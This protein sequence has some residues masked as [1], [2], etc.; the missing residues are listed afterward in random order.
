MREGAVLQFVDWRRATL[1][2]AESE[3]D[4]GGSSAAA[5]RSYATFSG[6][7][8]GCV[9]TS[10]EQQRR[11]DVAG[12]GSSRANARPRVVYVSRNDTAVRRVLQE[13]V[14]LRLLREAGE[15]DGWVSE[16]VL[17][18]RYSIGQTARLLADAAVIVGP[19]GAGLYNAVLFARAHGCG[20]GRPAMLVP[21]RLDRASREREANLHSACARVGL[22]I[23][24]PPGVSAPHKGNYSLNS[25]EVRAV[26]SSVRQ[27]VG[28]TCSCRLGDLGTRP[29]ASK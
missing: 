16:P 14:L 9:R 12:F 29:P 5:D 11:T 3:S 18:S 23:L 7:A 2:W 1:S 4:G 10:I 6:A 17:L 20:C 13:G 25:Q 15:R 28:R 24:Q 26:V 19:H 8:L 21:F 22:P 27:A